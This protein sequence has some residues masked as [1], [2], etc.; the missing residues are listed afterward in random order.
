MPRAPRCRGNIA[1]ADGRRR[2]EIRLAIGV[3]EEDAHFASSGSHLFPSP[4]WGR[5]GHKLVGVRG[6]EPH[7]SELEYTRF[8]VVYQ[9]KSQSGML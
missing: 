2:H 4:T 5:D 9:G 1:Q 6:I 8:G 7:F 3:D